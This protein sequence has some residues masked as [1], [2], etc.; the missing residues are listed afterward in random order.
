ML[1]TKNIEIKLQ[2]T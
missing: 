2:T 1:L